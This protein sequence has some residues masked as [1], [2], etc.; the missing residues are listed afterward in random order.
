MDCY[1]LQPGEIGSIGFAVYNDEFFPDK[2]WSE[3][4]NVFSSY[5]DMYKN[6]TSV[7]RKLLNDKDLYLQ[8]NESHYNEIRKLY[9]FNAFEDNLKRFYN[10]DYDFYPTEG[11]N[12]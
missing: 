6:I 5:D 12:E 2:S 7:M 1:F 4:L 3:M 11:K 10:R 9:D 8:T